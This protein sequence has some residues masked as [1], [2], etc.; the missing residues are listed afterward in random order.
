MTATSAAQAAQG[1]PPGLRGLLLDFDAMPEKMAALVA[2]HSGVVQGRSGPIRFAVVCDPGLARDL[3]TRPTGTT[4][5]RGIAVL[6]T[7]L[8]Q[9][10]LTSS[11]ELHKRQRRL[12][13]PAFHPGRIAVYATDAVRAARERSAQWLDGQRLD[14]AEEMSSLTLDVVGRTIFGMDV[15]EDAAT[16]A[17]AQGDLLSLFPRVMRPLG[18]LAVRLPTPLRRRVRRDVAALDEV[19][20]HVVAA[21]RAGGDA[22]DMVSMLL[23]VRDEETGEPMPARQVRDEVLTLLLAGHETTAVLLSWAWYELARDPEAAAW[24]DSELATPQALDALDRADWQALPVT[25]AVVAETLRL[26]PP[27]HTT[28]RVATTDLTLGE[29]P[30]RAGTVCFVSPFALGRDPKSWGPDADRWRPQRWLDADGRYDEAAPGQPRG[31]FLPFG[32]GSRVCIGAAFAQMEATLLLATLARDWRAEV[33][34]GFDPGLQ[35]LVTLRPRRGVPATL[36][37]RRGPT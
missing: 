24:L 15:T 8:G 29:E 11:G 13:Q 35:P 36:R 32:A 6:R 4:Q 17:R 30:V 31:A 5:G 20:E 7:I 34:P 25:R 19:V 16:V 1:P 27:A 37:A 22:G 14:L 21:R 23:A 10:L 28:T 26:R 9:G 18:L 12:V 2:T 33:A 3:L